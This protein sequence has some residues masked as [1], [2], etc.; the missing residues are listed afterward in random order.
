MMKSSRFHDLVK[1][2]FGACL[3]ENSHLMVNS[4]LKS[5]KPILIDSSMQN[6][7]ALGAWQ[8]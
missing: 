4:K 7:L 3:L 5:V 2:D 6:E 8:N 1:I